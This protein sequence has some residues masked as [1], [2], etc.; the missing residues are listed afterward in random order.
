MF[1]INQVKK[2]IKENKYFASLII[3]SF[4]LCF[5]LVFSLNKV[6]FNNELEFNNTTTAEYNYEI[7]NN[8]NILELYKKDIWDLFEIEF[9]P[10]DDFFYSIKTKEN[11]D[12]YEI[13]NNIYAIKQTKR[14]LV[15]S[16][17]IPEID[18]LDKEVAIPAI[19]A[20]KNDYDI[21]DKILINDIEY[22][23]IGLTDISMDDAFVF[24]LNSLNDM[25]FNSGKLKLCLNYDYDKNERKELYETYGNLF[26][27]EYKIANSRD[28]FNTIQLSWLP[29]ILIIIISTFNL[30]LIYLNILNSRKKM[31]S[32]Y[33]F[34]GIKIYKLVFSILIENFIVYTI[35]FIISTLI[36]LILDKIILN[37]IFNIF[38]YEF[39]FKLLMLIYILYLFIFM[40][41]LGLNVIKYTKRS[42][43]Q[44]YRS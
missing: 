37:K 7:K 33:R 19:F 41:V 10:Q 32:I 34:S 38:R 16:G 3:I 24:S 14:N 11:I 6:Y 8:K 42:L 31:Y 23:I 27:S 5:S 40:I 12:F 39:S 30:V 18:S 20:Y 44:V 35:S 4:I 17:R 21:G 15:Y 36:F 22:S 29:V 26:N 2:N 25:N 28:Y 1:Y 43:I 13:S 9:S